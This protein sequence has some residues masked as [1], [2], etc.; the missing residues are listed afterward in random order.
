MPKEKSKG[1]KFLPPP[2]Q[3]RGGI[4]DGAGRF[5][6]PPVVKGLKIGDVGHFKKNV[7]LVFFSRVIL[8]NGGIW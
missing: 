7:T 1:V 6:P 2:I 3:Q 4:K 8:D 5:C